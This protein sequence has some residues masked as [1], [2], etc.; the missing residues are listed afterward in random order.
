MGKND[1]GPCGNRSRVVL[2]VGVV[3]GGDVVVAVAVDVAA[4]VG[5]VGLG[6]V[7]AEV[8]VLYCCWACRWYCCE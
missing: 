2:V 7:E 6:V 3:D 8:V 5:G 4:G 1:T